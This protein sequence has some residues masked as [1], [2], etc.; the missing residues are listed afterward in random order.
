MCVRMLMCP[1]SQGACFPIM[2]CW[3]YYPEALPK[4]Y[5]QWITVFADMDTTLLL[6]LRGIYDGTVRFRCA[7]AS[8]L[9]RSL[10]TR[11][12]LS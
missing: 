4:V 1:P 6:A 5:R 3:F 7:D 11:S 10:L 12:P 2:F 9:F 8:S